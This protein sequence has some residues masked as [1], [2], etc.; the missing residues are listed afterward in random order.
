[1]CVCVGGYYST[2]WNVGL[3]VCYINR[4]WLE[5]WLRHYFKINSGYQTSK[6]F[7]K[8]ELAWLF[9]VKLSHFKFPLGISDCSVKLATGKACRAGSNAEVILIIIFSL[10]KKGNLWELNRMQWCLNMFIEA[11]VPAE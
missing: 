3:E 1:M 9:I 2:A 11:D 8:H 6:I 4:K 7:S 10:N 5:D